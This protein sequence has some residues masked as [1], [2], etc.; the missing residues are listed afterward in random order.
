MKTACGKLFSQKR[1]ILFSKKKQMKSCRLTGTKG[2]AQR[3]GTEP[4]VSECSAGLCVCYFDAT[5]A[6]SPESRV[7][8]SPVTSEYN[9]STLKPF[10]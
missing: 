2:V 3:S 4:S 10:S 7:R 8:G 5:M 1:M 9:A 6:I